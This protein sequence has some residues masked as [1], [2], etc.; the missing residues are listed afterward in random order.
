MNP[1]KLDLTSPIKSDAGVV[2]KPKSPQIPLK[3]LDLT[4]GEPAMFF[5][6]EDITSLMSLFNFTWSV[7][8]SALG[9]KIPKLLGDS[10][11]GRKSW[12][13]S[14]VHHSISLYSSSARTLPRHV[15]VRR[16]MPDVGKVQ[17]GVRD[18]ESQNQMPS[19]SAQV[20]PLPH[21]VSH[22]PIPRSRSRRGGRIIKRRGC[23]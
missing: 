7:W 23:H 21:P 10:N 5:S 19:S 3:H 4:K 16:S 8:L 2:G 9:L 18:L 6:D 12:R 17:L 20:Q 14:L 11:E 15:S 1:P 13:S 22:P